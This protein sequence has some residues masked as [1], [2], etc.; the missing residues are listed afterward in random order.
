MR[1]GPVSHTRC[2]AVYQGTFKVCEETL[3]LGRYDGE[4]GDS[5]FHRIH[6][7]QGHVKSIKKGNLKNAFAKHISIYHPEREEDCNTFKFKVQSAR[8]KEIGTH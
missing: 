5:A 4:T 3:T 6:G 8:R 1:V 7:E 2:G